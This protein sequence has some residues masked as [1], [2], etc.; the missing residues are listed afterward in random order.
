MTTTWLLQVASTAWALSPGG[1][2]QVRGERDGHA[3][4]L[5]ASWYKGGW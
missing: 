2:G 4:Y 5:P 1:Q 3:R